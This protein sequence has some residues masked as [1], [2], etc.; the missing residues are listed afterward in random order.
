MEFIN[1]NSKYLEKVVNLW[2]ESVV[3]YSIF[4]EFTVESFTNKFLKNVYFDEAGFKLLVDG[5]K[6]IGYGHA[7]VNNNEQAPGFITLIAV[8]KAYQRQGFGTKIL[9]ELES[10]LKSKGK[11]LIRLY[12]ASP[13]NLEWY[14][15]NTRCDH[16]GAPGVAFNSAYYYLLMNNGY[17]T[18]GQLDGYCLPITDYELPEKVK[19]TKKENEA[20]GYNIT[21]YDPAKHHGFEELFEALK[22]PG[23]YEAVKNNLSLEK[24]HPMLIVEKEGRI[25]GWTGPMYPQE[26]GRG[27]FAGIGVHPETQGHGLGKALF[28]ELCYRS[29]LY[30]AKFMTFFTGS[31]NLARNIYLY[32]GFKIVQSFAILRKELK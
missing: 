8:D 14:I 20:K 27:Y 32:A 13:I 31:D 23:W 21:L 16:P 30:G 3:P 19:Q 15:P 1:F 12:F 4:K 9:H 17:N 28:C 6:L 26:S 10:Y 24:P 18:N 29:K 7:I 25:L 11:T 5:D 2:N 22:N